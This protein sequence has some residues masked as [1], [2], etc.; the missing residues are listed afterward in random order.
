LRGRAGQFVRPH[1]PRGFSI[2]TMSSSS[3]MRHLHPLL[4]SWEMLLDRHPE[5]VLMNRKQVEALLEC[6]LESADGVALNAPL[7][8]PPRPASQQ[9]ATVNVSGT[10]L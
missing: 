10:L 8:S 3:A 6:L 9:Q 4:V 7:R 2:K 5:H 1:L